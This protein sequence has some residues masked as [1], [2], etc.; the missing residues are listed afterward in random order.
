MNDKKT[1]FFYLYTK[2]HL[3]LSCTVKIYYSVVKNEISSV[4][5]RYFN[6]VQQICKII[7]AATSPHA[8]KFVWW[9]CVK[10]M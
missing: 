2:C 5:P 3:I 8:H 6:T 7:A 10:L 1:D 4:V 9:S